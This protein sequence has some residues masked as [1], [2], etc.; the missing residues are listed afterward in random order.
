MSW[1]ERPGAGP[2]APGGGLGVTESWAWALWG[3]VGRPGPG[4]WAR[5]GGGE[6]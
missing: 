4:P 1:G 3:E 6:G 5:W 2:G